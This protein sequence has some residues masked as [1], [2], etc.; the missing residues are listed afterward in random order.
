M[1]AAGRRAAKKLK[2]SVQKGAVSVKINLNKVR[3]NARSLTTSMRAAGKRGATA[4]NSEVTKGVSKTVRI[5]KKLGTDINRQMDEAWKRMQTRASTAMD[6]LCATVTQDAQRAAN[7]VRIAFETMVIKIPEPELPEIKVTRQTVTYGGG[8]SQGQVEIPKFTTVWHAEGGI[9]KK[10]TLFGT[11]PG[12]RHGVGES[13]PEAVLPLDLLWQR[14]GD[15]VNG[16]SRDWVDQ[17]LIRLSRLEG[18]PAGQGPQ[19]MQPIMISEGAFVF[20][21]TYNPTYNLNGTASEEDIMRA[22]RASQKELK[23]MFEKM[24]KEYKKDLERTLFR[25]TR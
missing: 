6:T 16:Y 19:Q 17:L 1:D 20:Q 23:R 5:T 25:K 24:W 2:S 4:L 15:I 12:V 10:P 7:A 3:V 11:A 22:D 14:L 13:G 21:T 8:R 18:V 9:F